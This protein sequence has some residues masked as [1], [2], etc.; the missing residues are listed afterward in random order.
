MSRRREAYRDLYQSGFD[1]TALFA[2]ALALA[3]FFLVAGGGKS[4]A[5]QFDVSL[6]AS[7][8]PG[9]DKLP[10]VNI[11]RDGQLRLS[12][13]PLSLDELQISLSALKQH[14]NIDR[15][16][17]V[18]DPGARLQSILEAM[19]AIKAAGINRVAQRI[20]SQTAPSQ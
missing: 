3:G 7:A 4:G 19:S 1:F 6:S 9:D 17:V 12:G 15:V 16:V 13:R 11:A 20:Q 8:L 2:V 10:V 18:T 14:Q 5:A